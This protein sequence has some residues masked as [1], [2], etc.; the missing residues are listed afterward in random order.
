MDKLLIGAYAMIL[1][2]LAAWFAANEFSFY[3]EQEELERKEREAKDKDDSG[4]V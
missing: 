3:K 2:G 4:M 1:F